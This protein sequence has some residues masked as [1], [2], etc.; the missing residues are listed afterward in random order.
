MSL[1][2]KEL[3][4]LS[5]ALYYCASGLFYTDCYDAE[6]PVSCEYCVLYPYKP[7]AKDCL[8]DQCKMNTELFAANVLQAEAERREE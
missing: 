4:H 2:T 8:C 5:D 7:N 6:L 1:S 3:K